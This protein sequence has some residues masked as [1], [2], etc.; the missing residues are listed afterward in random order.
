MGLPP[1]IAISEKVRWQVS[2]SNSIHPFSSDFAHPYYAARRPVREPARRGFHMVSIRVVV[3]L[4]SFLRQG[5]R[6][7]RLHGASRR[8]LRMGSVGRPGRG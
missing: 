6:L 2:L 7:L 1:E 4:A 3:D 5:W 8:G